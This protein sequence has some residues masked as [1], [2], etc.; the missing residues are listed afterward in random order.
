MSNTINSN[1]SCLIIIQTKTYMGMCMP[2][3]IYLQY[4]Q[5]NTSYNFVKIISTVNVVN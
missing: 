4:L 2:N 3:Y 5:M 1:R